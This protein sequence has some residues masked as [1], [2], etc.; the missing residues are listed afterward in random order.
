MATGK[1][2]ELDPVISIESWACAAAAASRAVATSNARIANIFIL[3][4]SGFEKV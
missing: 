3:S 4:G 1:R 2:F